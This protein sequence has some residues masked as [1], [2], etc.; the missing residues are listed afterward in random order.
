MNSPKHSLSDKY[1]FDHDDESLKNWSK[2][3]ELGPK[4]DIQADWYSLRTFE[5]F[6][7]AI[8][9]NQ[10][11]LSDDRRS[12]SRSSIKENS[13]ATSSNGKPDSDKLN[14]STS[15]DEANRELRQNNNVETILSAEALKILSELPDLS[16]ISATRTF[17]FPNSKKRSPK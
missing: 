13:D 10:P 16:H 8:D 4:T 12:R 3:L 7:D 15:L 6:L 17:I 5:V 14:N 1:K 9:I 2:V 11:V